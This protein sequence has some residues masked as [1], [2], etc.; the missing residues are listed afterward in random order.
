[1]TDISLPH[2]IDSATVE[3]RS[4][5]LVPELRFY[6]MTDHYPGHSLAREEYLRLMERPPYWAFCW[7]GGQALARWILDHPERV[8]GRD[9]V[10]FGAGSGVA[11]IAAARCGAMS[12]QAVD[13]D[14]DA[15]RVCLLNAGLNGVS[16]RVAEQMEEGADPLLLAADV[17][18]EDAGFAAV[19]RHI[20]SGGQAIIAES[21]LRDLH[22]RFPALT[23]QARFQIR[24]FPDLEEHSMFDEV[25][26]YAT[27]ADPK[28]L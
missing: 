20:E 21:R 13:I 16:L 10:D 19:V 14:Q 22:L 1:M 4:L 9:V 27:G 3:P 2:I 24:T 11:G 12:V 18:Y 23:L 8:R 7:G 15:L 17:G 28:I 6:L 5:P 25:H 26:I